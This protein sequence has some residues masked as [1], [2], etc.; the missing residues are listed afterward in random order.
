MLVIA[1][2]IS[3]GRPSRLIRGNR[4]SLIRRRRK[5]DIIVLLKFYLE[6]IFLIDKKYVEVFKPTTQYKAV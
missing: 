4:G 2:L 5:S 6:K 1:I 3:K